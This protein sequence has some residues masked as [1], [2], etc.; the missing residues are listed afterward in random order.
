MSNQALS[1]FCFASTKTLPEIAALDLG[2][3]GNILPIAV[4]DVTAWVSEVAREEYE[5]PEAEQR[6]Q[7]L[8]WVGPRAL[9]HGTVISKIMSGSPVL[10]ARFGTLFSSAEALLG[11][12][13]INHTAIGQFLEQV[14]GSEEW[15]VKGFFSRTA[16]GERLFQDLLEE[17]SDDLAA[18]SPGVR[19]FK[20]QQLRTLVEKEIGHWLKAACS[21]VAKELTACSRDSIKRPLSSLSA[22][23]ADGSEMVVNWAC[24]VDSDCLPEFLAVVERSNKAFQEW[25]LSFQVSG[26]WPPYSFGPTLLSEAGQ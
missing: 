14:R 17:R 2:D 16:A 26:P 8:S 4:E 11:F 15:A 18:N 22:V 9:R 7:D 3:D 20:E 25:G 12:M 13:R 24:L 19:Y 6:L 23:E 5:G 21:S 10:P 1:L